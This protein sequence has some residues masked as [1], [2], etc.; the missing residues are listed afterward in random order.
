M[1]RG[2]WII[3]AVSSILMAALIGWLVWANKALQMNTYVVDGDLPVAFNGYRIAQVSD[4]H[5]ARMGKDNHKLLTLLREADPD[6]IAITGD[7]IDSRRTDLDVAIAF[8]QDA[9]KIAP[10]Y[11]VPGNHE[12]RIAEYLQ[13]K[14]ALL[15]AG[16]VILEDA[17]AE[18]IHNGERITLAGLQDPDFTETDDEET[19]VRQRLA[20]LLEPSDGFTILLSHRPEF[21]PV[22]AESDVDLVLSGHAHGGQV[23]L[24]YIGGVI[25]PGQGLFPEYDGGLYSRESTQMVVS[26]GIGNSLCPLRVNNR[27]E[28]VLVELRC[29]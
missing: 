6:M 19:L 23:R 12:S 7:L 15:A 3:I 22:Y 18:I 5:N 25:A 14:E 26:R 9:A 29:K 28:V 1:K 21:I 2:K 10:C 8:V 27:P 13:L 20:E 4:L 24:P 16:V 17:K 11:Y